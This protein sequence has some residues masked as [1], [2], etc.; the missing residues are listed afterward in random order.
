MGLNQSQP[1]DYCGAGTAWDEDLQQCTA[2]PAPGGI[3]MDE[4][5]HVVGKHVYL[6]AGDNLRTGSAASITCLPFAK[7]PERAITDPGLDGAQLFSEAQWT[8]LQTLK[9]E[10]PEAYASCL[11]PGL[12]KVSSDCGIETLSIRTVGS[13]QM[14]PSSIMHL[15]DPTYV[16]PTPESSALTEGFPPGSAPGSAPALAPA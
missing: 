7:A 15:I 13:V 2:R 10:A 12:C 3:H 14:N 6:H 11:G 9:T 5:I 1:A 4:G 8:C 16:P